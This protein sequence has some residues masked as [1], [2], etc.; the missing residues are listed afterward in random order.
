MQSIMS[1]SK[2]VYL[3][4]PLL[5]QEEEHVDPSTTMA[6]A[7]RHG[8]EESSPA[9]SCQVSLLISFF[10][11]T[12]MGIFDF[13]AMSR[14]ILPLLLPLLS[15]DWV[16]STLCAIIWVI[17]TTAVAFLPWFGFI[18]FCQCCRW[19]PSLASSTQTMANSAGHEETEDWE[20]D[21]DLDSDQDAWDQLEFYFGVGVIVGFS[22]AWLIVFSL[23]GVRVN[24][25]V[26]EYVLALS[27]ACLTAMMT[28]RHLSNQSPVTSMTKRTVLPIVIV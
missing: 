12:C 5:S 6:D 9:L 26:F 15:N 28:R 18:S 11:G 2:A 14:V 7:R 8:C 25:L 19:R 22:L 1:T 21:D 3:A 24:Y 16:D 23:A 10:A 20:D 13:Y 17:T 27:W 4:V